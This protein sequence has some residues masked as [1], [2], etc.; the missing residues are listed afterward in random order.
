MILLALRAKLETL[1]AATTGSTSI[2][3]TATGYARASGSFISD[4]FAV[5]MEIS[6]SDFLVTANNNRKTITELTATT[7]TCAGNSVEAADTGRT[8]EALIPQDVASANI[9]FTPTVGRPYFQED[10][11]PGPQTGIEIGETAEQEILPLYIVKVFVPSDTAI[12]GIMLYGTALLALFA[13]GTAF[14]VS[15]HTVR[16]RRDLA[17]FAGQI[18]QLD[19]FAVLTITVPLR[20]RTANS[21]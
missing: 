20:V 21:I 10:Y 14:T 2:E 5:G 11:I 8:V 13:P 7:I 3:A 6:G 19:G 1:E 12:R 9:E 16:S 4:G 15:G 18:L 17:P